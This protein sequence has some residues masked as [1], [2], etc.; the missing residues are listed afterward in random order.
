MSSREIRHVR[1]HP[2][3]G[4]VIELTEAHCGEDSGVTVENMLRVVAA[5]EGRVW[6]KQYGIVGHQLVLLS[7]WQKRIDD[8]IKSELIRGA[9]HDAPF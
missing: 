1:H 8:A 2:L 6:F 5:K 3:P 9:D 7:D 4:D